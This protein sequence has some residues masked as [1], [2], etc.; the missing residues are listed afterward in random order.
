MDGKSL[1]QLIKGETKTHR[2]KAFFNYNNGPVGPRFSSRAVTDGRFKLMWNLTPDNLFAVR[3]INGFDFGYED[4]MKDRHVRA[5]YRS[6]LEKAGD[7]SA[8]ATA[9]QRFRKQPEF[10]LYELSQDPWERNNLAANPAYATQV[11]ELKD[12]I[13]S[14][15]QK[16]GDT[17]FYDPEKKDQK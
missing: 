2:E 9:V 1:L 3:T 10:Q 17:G 12:S 15:M 13:Q 16:Q 4:T 11:R 8:A 7:D 5:M 6:W 14:W